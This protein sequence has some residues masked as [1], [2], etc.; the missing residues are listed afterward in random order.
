MVEVFLIAN[1]LLG[2]GKIY[3]EDAVSSGQPM[4]LKD[5]VATYAE[6]VRVG[7]TSGLGWRPYIGNVK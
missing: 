3:C 5:V 1:E 6:V 2:S 7:Y 4:K